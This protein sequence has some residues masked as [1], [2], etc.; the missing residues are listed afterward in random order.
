LP[1]K[2]TPT[3]TVTCK[4][5][6]T[7]NGFRVEINGQISSNGS[8]IANKAVQ[9]Y[10]SN[11]GGVNWESLT[12]VNSDSNG[13][14][15]AVWM[16]SVSGVFLLKAVSEANSEYNQATTQVNFV[17]SET[18]DKN[19]FSVTSN[20]TITEFKFDSVANELSFKAE[21]AT[22]TKGY[23][24]VN[25]PKTLI[26]DISNLKVYFDENEVTF[27]SELQIDTWIITIYYTHSAHTIVM[28]L[29]GNGAS[30][31]DNQPL[32][33]LP[34]YAIAIIAIVIVAVAAVAVLRKKQKT[35][36]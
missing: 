11:N 17:I 23:V 24:T 31:G 30:N 22:N 34:I 8:G 13:K 9:L 14:F 29:S 15:S 26:E 33:Q 4:S 18:P 10:Y 25:V 6:A 19:V 27:N 20:S 2:P 7:A 12:L 16:P 35:T 3:T 21:G 28:D 36:N 1:N 5:T 32:G